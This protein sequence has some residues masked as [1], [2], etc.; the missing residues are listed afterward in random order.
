MTIPD[1]KLEELRIPGVLQRLAL[2]YFIVAVPHI[3]FASSHIDGVS[4]I[5]AKILIIFPLALLEVN[6]AAFSW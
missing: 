2:C 4:L 5:S 6:I 3:F 1:M